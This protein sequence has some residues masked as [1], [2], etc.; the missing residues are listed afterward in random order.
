MED[1][2]ILPTLAFALII[3]GM[4]WVYHSRET[5][6]RIGLDD[7]EPNATYIL[8]STKEIGGGIIY[9]DETNATGAVLE[10]RFGYA[11]TL[12]KVG[13]G[14]VLGGLVLLVF[15]FREDIDRVINK[16]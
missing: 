5:Q 11:P 4:Y 1:I 12:E 3:L 15:A 13:I 16:L 2:K 8:K 6:E 9:V 14:M 10:E 7:L